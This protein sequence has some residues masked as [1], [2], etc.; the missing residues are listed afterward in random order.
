MSIRRYCL[1]VLLFATVLGVGSAFAECSNESLRGTYGVIFSNGFVDG[2]PGAAIGQVIFDGKGN[3]TGSQ[4]W[5]V[6]TWVESFPFTGTYS[7]AANCTGALWVSTSTYNFVLDEDHKQAQFIW[8]DPGF[9]YTGYAVKQ[10]DLLCLFCHGS[11]TYAANLAGSTVGVGNI[12]IVGQLTLDR[13]GKI[14]G[15][16]TFSITH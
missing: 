3:V 14:T 16:G 2:E 12:G 11:H 8:A 7:I 4:T 6:P 9:A 1:A 13:H 15:S 10:G 5:S